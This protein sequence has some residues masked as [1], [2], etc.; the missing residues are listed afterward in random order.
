MMERVLGD[1]SRSE[2]QRDAAELAPFIVAEQPVMLN[3]RQVYESV[4]FTICAILIAAGPL[5]L[6]FRPLTGFAKPPKLVLVDRPAIGM[7]IQ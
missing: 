1:L 6:N 7:L 5:L 4:D 3:E 2:V